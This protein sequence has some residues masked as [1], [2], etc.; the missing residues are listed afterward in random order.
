[1][2]PSLRNHTPP[3]ADVCYCR[4]PDLQQ[5]SAEAFGEIM[6][7]VGRNLEIENRRKFMR[8]V[9]QFRAKLRPWD[10]LVLD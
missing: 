9:Q 3:L 4:F 7:N 10:E 6:S 5:R 1:M 8:N 2:V